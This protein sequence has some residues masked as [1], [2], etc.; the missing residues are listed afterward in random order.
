MVQ[1]IEK[2]FISPRAYLD[3]ATNQESP[4][5]GKLESR[6]GTYDFTSTHSYETAYDLARYGWKEGLKKLQDA[7]RFAAA[8][9][10]PKAPAPARRFD[11][12]G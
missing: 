8:V 6:N 3:W 9:S 11:V 4:W 10:L 1:L 2:F 7:S 5:K 12:A